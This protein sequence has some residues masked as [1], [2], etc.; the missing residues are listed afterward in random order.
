MKKDGTFL[1]Q[2]GPMR[3]QRIGKKRTEEIECQGVSFFWLSL[4]I[5][6]TV[7]ASISS[8]VNSWFPDNQIIFFVAFNNFKIS[9]S[10]CI[11]EF[12]KIQCVLFN[13]QA[14]SKLLSFAYRYYI[15]KV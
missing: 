9:R 3:D 10:K 1:L 13:K 4:V 8:L 2:S 7:H 5:I 14:E 12:T 15:H 11:L 6:G